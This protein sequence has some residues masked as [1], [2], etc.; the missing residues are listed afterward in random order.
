VRACFAALAIAACT[1]CDVA[2]PVVD[3]LPKPPM[4]PPDV[5]RISVPCQNPPSC[6]TELMTD[7]GVTELRPLGDDISGLDE[8]AGV[9]KALDPNAIDWDGDSI[10]L[11]STTPVEV[12]HGEAPE[13]GALIELRG[14]VTLRFEH[15]ASLEGVRIA[16]VS[17]ESRLVLDHVTALDLTLGDGEH[18]FA[19]RLEAKHTTFEGASVNAAHISLDS[20]VFVGSFIE[21]ETFVSRDGLMLNAILELGDGFFAPTELRDTEI[22][23]CDALSFFQSSLRDVSIARCR[24]D[25]PTRLYQSMA[26]RGVLDG[27][28]LADSSV[29]EAALLGQKEETSLLMWETAAKRV[30]VCDFAD[31]VQLGAS[32]IQCSSCT[33]DALEGLLCEV[34]Q[35]AERPAEWQ[36]RYNYCDKL[37]DV[38]RCEEPLPERPRPQVEE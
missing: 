30:A 37:D 28:L 34:R 31:D 19:G 16:S 12:V 2:G 5:D 36:G 27:V 18:R 10:E 35:D 8:D 15:V 17:P 4:L 22:R 7:G 3:R 13:A 20:V 11:T 21:A 26:V 14:P 24:S 9:E 6:E 23:R 29:I 25:V 33:E 32:A 1:A 38:A